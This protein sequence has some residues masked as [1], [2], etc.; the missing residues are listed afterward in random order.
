MAATTID[1]RELIKDLESL[2]AVL[3]DDSFGEE[4]YRALSNT[5]WRKSDGPDGHLSLSWSR[6]EAVVN[7]LR[8]REGQEP[9]VLSQTGGEGDVS[10][11]VGHE[12]SRLGWS[13]KAL[14]TSREDPGHTSADRQPEQR[15]PANAQWAEQAHAEADEDRGAS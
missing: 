5:T 2:G 15:T 13:S 12:L 9:L 14:N 7:Q 3:A 4:L 1:E 10:D 8:E 11:R 6:A